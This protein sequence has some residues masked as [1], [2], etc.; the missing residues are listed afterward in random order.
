MKG[1]LLDVI[2]NGKIVL[3]FY[4]VETHQ[5]I[6]WTDTKFYTPY[7]L[8]NHLTQE[9]IEDLISCDGY[10]G[11]TTVRKTNPFTNKKQ[12]LTKI[13]VKSPSDV[14]KLRRYA[15]YSKEDNIQFHHNYIYDNKLKIGQLYSIYEDRIK[16]IKTLKFFMFF[17]NA[18]LLPD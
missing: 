4:D 1:I 12:E 13:F 17:R 9:E 16:E 10:N 2:Y 14:P 5:I 3:K 11:Y 7:F 6:K 15:L 8:A 18:F